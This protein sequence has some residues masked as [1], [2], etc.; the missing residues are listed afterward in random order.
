MTRKIKQLLFTFVFSLTIALTSLVGLAS[1]SEVLPQYNDISVLRA[2]LLT[3]DDLESRNEIAAELANRQRQFYA[4]R[5][6][7]FQGET[8]TV[9]NLRNWNQFTALFRVE[10]IVKVLA[11][12]VSLIGAWF[13]FGGVLTEIFKTISGIFLR[14]LLKVRDLLLKIPAPVYEVAYCGVGAY[15]M[16]FS[17]GLTPNFFGAAIFFLSLAL[18]HNKTWDSLFTYSENNNV[19]FVAGMCCIAYAGA[20]W[21]SQSTTLGVLACLAFITFFGFQLIAGPLTLII[22]FDSAD[23]AGQ[24]TFAAGCLMIFGIV[25]TQNYLPSSIDVFQIGALFAGTF[26]YFLGMVILSSKWLARENYWI[27][28]II[29]F[30]SGP[31]LIYVATSLEL[32]AVN[33]ISGTFFVIFLIDKYVEFCALWVKDKI[34]FGA[35]LLGVGLLGFGLIQVFESYPQYFIHL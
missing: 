35:A 32:G 5:A 18:L 4:D 31:A 24:G 14:I 12:I 27:K 17:K 16:F 29:T 8:I 15:L 25:L 33:A 21:W 10:S 3:I 34:G 13:F 9:T 11:A 26:V 23:K 22:G 19:N 20:A 2:H 28:N 6:S 7:S 30:A 1:A